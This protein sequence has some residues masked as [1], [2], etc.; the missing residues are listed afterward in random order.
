MKR[1]DTYF[2]MKLERI[3]GHHVGITINSDTSL[4]EIIMCLPLRQAQFLSI[5]KREIGGRFIS[6]SEI[7]ERCGT[8]TNSIG[9]VGAS[10][11][12]KL[13]PSRWTIDSKSSRMGGGYRLVVR[14]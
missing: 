11:R 12:A 5:L 3:R 14:T 8:I 6:S 10:V 4:D 2:A 7:A 9:S 1:A 13:R